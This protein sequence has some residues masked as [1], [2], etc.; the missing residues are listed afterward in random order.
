MQLHNYEAY[1]VGSLLYKKIFYSDKV[2]AFYLHLKHFMLIQ[3][4]GD[5]FIS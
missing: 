1:T 4:Q 5:R 3:L 2:E